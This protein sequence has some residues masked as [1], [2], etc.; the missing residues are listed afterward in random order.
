MGKRLGD[1]RDFE[2]DDFENPYGKSGE[3]K[4]GTRRKD[5]KK[6]N[7]GVYRDSNK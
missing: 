7:K 4:K 1:T 6:G 3:K 2:K 5:T